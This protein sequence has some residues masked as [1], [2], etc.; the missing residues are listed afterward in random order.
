MA[1]IGNANVD[2]SYKLGAFPRVDQVVIA[3][4]YEIGSGGSASNYAYAA[5]RLGATSLFIGAVGD[6]VLGE[7]FLRELGRKG[8]DVS[9]IQVVPNEKTGTVTIWVDDKGEKHGVGWRGANLKLTPAPEWKRLNG[10]NVVHLGGCP[11]GITRWVVSEIKTEKSFD[12]GSASHLYTPDDLLYAV[13]N[14]KLSFLSEAEIS[15]LVSRSGQ[16]LSDLVS[17]NDA[18]IVEKMGARGVRLYVEKRTFFVKPLSI[19]AT[20]TTGAGDVFSATFDYKFLLERDAVE[21]AYWATA[22]ASLKVRSMG[23]KNGVPTLDELVRF[24]EA[25]REKFDEAGARLDS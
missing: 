9:L 1:A 7:Y 21:A 24:L 17:S 6:D 14:C 20:D 22:S 15:R 5:A 10:V 11:P 2:V 13:S 12:P 8:V 23:A 18:V 16:K 4:E 19:A 3:E 25:N